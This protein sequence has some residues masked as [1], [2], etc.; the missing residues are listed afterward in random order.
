MPCL[1]VMSGR[2]FPYAQTWTMMIIVVVINYYLSD[3]DDED[4][5][6][7]DD[8]SDDHTRGREGGRRGQVPE[9]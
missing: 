1:A 6:E 7:C 3:R 2:S 4:Y 8:D 9:D 5:G